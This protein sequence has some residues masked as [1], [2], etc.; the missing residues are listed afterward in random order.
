M[1]AGI[2]FIIIV[3]PSLANRTMW[4]SFNMV[5]KWLCYYN[6]LR[7]EYFFHP[8]LL[9]LSIEV[10]PLKPS[11]NAISSTESPTSPPVCECSLC[12]RFLEHRT[13]LAC[14]PCAARGSSSCIRQSL[15]LTLVG[16][17]AAGTAIKEVE[18]CPKCRKWG[19]WFVQSAVTVRAG[20]RFPSA[21]GL[22]G[23][24]LG[25]YVCAGSWK[26]SRSEIA[27]MAWV[28]REDI[29]SGPFLRMQTLKGYLTFFTAHW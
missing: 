17:P 25:R 21:R 4:G 29:I 2:I 9:S 15:L 8:F 13:V 6:F 28:D 22:H 3:L 7:L 27:G 23:S 14:T 26:P 5:L 11:S 24:L 16:G 20:K 12:F 18:P 19:V 1:L 10:Q